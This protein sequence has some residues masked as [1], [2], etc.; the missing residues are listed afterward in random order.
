MDNCLI[1]RIITC[2]RILSYLN[3]LSL[4]Y[5]TFSFFIGIDIVC[6]N[7][8]EKETSIHSGHMFSVYSK[9]DSTD[10]INAHFRESIYRK[11]LFEM[12]TLPQCE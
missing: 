11:S 3:K 6:C 12:F 4:F 9:Y 1:L 10:D 8:I 7:I 5:S 2:L